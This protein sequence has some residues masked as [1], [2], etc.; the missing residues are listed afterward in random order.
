VRLA[1]MTHNIWAEN[2][3]PQREPALRGLLRTRRPDVYAVQE[4]QPATRAGSTPSSRV[5]AGWRTTNVAG[6]TRARSGGMRGC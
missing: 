5:T 1:V 4:L 6:A 2:R 3:W